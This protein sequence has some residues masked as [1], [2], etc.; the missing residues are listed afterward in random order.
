[1][2]LIMT[3]PRKNFG[4]AKLQNVCPTILS[5]DYK[6]PKLV[7]EMDDDTVLTRIPLPLDVS[8]TFHTVTTRAGNFGVTNILGDG[9]YPLNGV[10][11]I[12]ESDF[13]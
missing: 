10:L 5:T 13:S 11:E 2:A 9:H 12:Y 3:D 6:S 1:M 7:I 8:D 4:D